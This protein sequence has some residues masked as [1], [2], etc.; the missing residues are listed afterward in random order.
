MKCQKSQS[1]RALRGREK[2]PPPT[3]PQGCWAR[4]V[5]L[6][7]P[8]LIS[9]AL[10]LPTID[11]FVSFCLLTEACADT[12]DKYSSRVRFSSAWIEQ[13]KQAN[14]KTIQRSKALRRKL[15]T[16]DVNNS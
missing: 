10:I 12:P 16:D 9:P 14:R 13:Y 2:L 8:T 15:F 3:P 5:S 7:S 1:F 4:R 11:Q 6:I